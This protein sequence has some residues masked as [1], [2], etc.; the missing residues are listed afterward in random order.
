MES[1]LAFA[2]YI[3]WE[4]II[5]RMIIDNYMQYLVKYCNQRKI[6]LICSFFSTFNMPLPLLPIIFCQHCGKDEQQEG[7]SYMISLILN[8]FKFLS[9]HI[10]YRVNEFFDPSLAEKLS[11][12]S[13]CTI[14]FLVRRIQ[15]NRLSCFTFNY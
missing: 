4:T 2:K 6:S 5:I 9:T 10:K 11:F 7:W 12:K 8:N 1:K 15:I 14:L 3:A 13:E